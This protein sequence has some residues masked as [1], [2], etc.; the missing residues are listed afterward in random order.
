MQAC[1]SGVYSRLFEKLRLHHQRG[2]TVIGTIVVCL[3]FGTPL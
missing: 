1:V 3:L 2:P